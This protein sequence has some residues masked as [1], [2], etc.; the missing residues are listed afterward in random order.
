MGVDRPDP[1]VSQD[2]LDH[3]GVLDE[4]D[5]PHWSRT[6]G[7]AERVHFVDLLHCTKGGEGLSGAR[8][9][10]IKAGVGPTRVR[11]YNAASECGAPQLGLR[12]LLQGSGCAIFQGG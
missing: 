9:M 10:A 2:L 3:L 12:Q 11:R 7:I 8:A 6:P 5:D 4:R 1:E